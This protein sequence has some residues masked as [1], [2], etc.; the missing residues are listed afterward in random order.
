MTKLVKNWL[1][2]VHVYQNI[3]VERKLMEFYVFF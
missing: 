3:S 2:T 1:K